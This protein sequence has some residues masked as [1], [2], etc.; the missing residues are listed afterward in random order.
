M[1]EGEADVEGVTLRRFAVQ[2]E[3]SSY[4]TEL[5]RRLID[6]FRAGQLVARWPRALQEEFIRAQGPWSPGLLHHLRSNAWKF[7]AF[8]FCTYL[9]PTTYFGLRQV[10]ASRAILVPTLHDEMTAY[11]SVF[12]DAAAAV[13][14]CVWLT[15]AERDVAARCWGIDTGTVVGMAVESVGGENAVRPPGDAEEKYFLYVGRTD[16]EKGCRVLLSAFDKVRSAYSGKLKLV[17]AGSM[18][19]DI[20]DPRQVEFLG[21]VDETEKLRLMAG[22]TA[23]VM[24][25]AYESFSI[26]TLEA[27]SCGAPVLANA[28]C[29]VLADHVAVSDAGRCFGNEEELAEAMRWSLALDEGGRKRIAK[30]GMDYVERNFSRKLIGEKLCAV[31]FDDCAS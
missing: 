7:D 29:S 3:R 20:G 8:V 4:F 18:N 21:F 1:P 27:M 25:S 24:P 30:A 11:L 17:L 15:R 31:A 28:A 13:R 10:P 22:A 23:F 2:Q 19:M 6:D 16:P 26:V 14:H 5:H 12:R 9:Y